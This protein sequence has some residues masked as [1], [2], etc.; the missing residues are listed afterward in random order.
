M[1]KIRFLFLILLI[2]AVISTGAFWAGCSAGE[3]GEGGRAADFRLENLSGAQVSLDSFKGEKAVLLVF[4]ATWCPPCREEIPH[5]K[6]IYAQYQAQGL[7]I[8][9]ISIKESREKLTSFARENGINY[10][11]LMDKDGSIASAY[12]VMGIPTNVIVDKAGVIQFKGNALPDEVLL[13]KVVK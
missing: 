6:R 8:L 5:L 13:E 10:P 3:L 11:V 9:A 4:W 12:Q 1:N 2:T 7:E